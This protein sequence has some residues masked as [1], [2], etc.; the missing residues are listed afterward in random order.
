[1]QNA[2]NKFFRSLSKVFQVPT[3]S[4][5][6]QARK[7]LKPEVFLYLNQS[8]CRDFYDLYGKDGEV[9]LWQGHR[10][11]GVDGSYL[12]LPD[13]PQT[14]SEFT[15]QTNQYA[16][17]SQVQALISVLYD[18]LQDIGLDASIGKK[19]AE[20]NFLFESHLA[21]VQA[22][23]VIVADR[24]YADFTVMAMIQKFACHF[25]I[26]CSVERFKEVQQF[27]A[28]SDNE[29]VVTLHCSKPAK[30]FVQSQDLPI[31]L[32]V[33]L[34]K[35][36]LDT[37]E[38][39][40]LLTD[41]LEATTYPSDEL[42]KVYGWR[43]GS[44]TYYGRIKNIFEVERFSSTS[45]QAIKQDF[46]GVLFLAT[47]ESILAKPA[48]KELTAH[49]RECGNRNPP[50]VNRSVSYVTV[51]DYVVELLCDPNISTQDTLASIEHLLLTNPIRHAVG[52]KFERKKHRAY[53]MK[54]RFYKYIKR[55][56]S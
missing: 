11:L 26:R 5:Y 51:L 28:S 35:I 46:Y 40:V 45:V 15:V 9:D 54:L 10:L 14:R 53:S 16:K 42:N 37:G 3:A 7:K 2:L 29:W 12:N 41:L 13:T 27:M 52:R 34:V 32:K 22:N 4:A 1:M 36:L 33:R 55:V 18:L 24:N 49:S 23:D 50:K 6:S 20:K 31:C 56:I 43:W 38:V 25:V 30:V 44:E 48:Q 39:E 47:L 21:H 17:A 8:V 19:Q